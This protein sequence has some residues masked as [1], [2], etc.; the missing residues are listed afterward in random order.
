MRR[1]SDDA[2]R[3]DRALAGQAIE[4][5]ADAECGAAEADRL[6]EL[7]RDVPRGNALDITGEGELRLRRQWRHSAE[8][9]G[10]VAY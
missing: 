8:V 6:G 3:G 10:H 4:E 7:G 2:E 5:F 9:D 1:S